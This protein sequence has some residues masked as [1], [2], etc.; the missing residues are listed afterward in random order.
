[1]G[2]VRRPED[3]WMPTRV[4]RGRTQYEYHPK[5]GKAVML[6]PLNMEQHEVWAAYAEASKESALTV[7]K[8][9]ARYEASR[10]FTR[11][12]PSTQT[13]YT[14]CW[15]ML[16]KVWTGVDAARV[17]PKHVREWMDKRGEKSEVSAN[18]EHSVL[19]NLFAY[20]YERGLVK[21][22]PCK[23]V[24]KFPEKPRTRYIE[25]AEYL[26]YLKH[27]TPLIQVLM[28][29]TYLQGSRPGEVRLIRLP[30]IRDFGVFI[31]TAKG[32]KKMIKEFTNRLE[33]AI[34]LAHRIRSEILN[35]L[36]ARGEANVLSPYLI[37]NKFG[38]PY[39]A[40]GLKTMW[41]KNRQR[42]KEEHGIVIDWTHHDIK[43]KGISDYEGDKVKFAGH[44][45]P[46]TTDIYDRRTNVVATVQSELRPLQEYKHD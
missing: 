8:L 10:N 45:N 4:Y 26:P 21:L 32:G 35:R 28:E 20:G 11:R 17:K 19:S 39:T 23:G 5:S 2:R 31:Q 18:R 40:R 24:K 42:L 3:N 12:K 9:W 34:A 37:V 15:N 27:S 25:D 6:G 16:E 43:A 30:D 33:D 29:L 44:Q 36:T 13:Q 22:N 41:A 38:Q 46:R 14:E 7:D 1:M